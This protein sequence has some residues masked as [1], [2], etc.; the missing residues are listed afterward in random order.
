VD[1]IARHPDRLRLATVAAGSRWREVVALAMAHGAEAVALRD[2]EAAARAAERLAGTGVAVLSG[3]EGV[4]EA[5]AWPSVDVAVIA[6]SGIAGLVP[7]LAALGAGKDVA[8]ANKES[9]VAGGRLVTQAAAAHGARLLPVDSEH[10]A[11]FQCL[12]GRAA[13]GVRRLWLTASG[14]PFRTYP[15]RRLAQVTPAQA[16][17][18]PTW[19]MGPRVTV[20]SATLLNKGFE[21]IEASWLFGLAPQ[22]IQVVVHPQSVVHSFVEFVDGSVMAQCAVPD[23]RLPIQFALSY[24]ERWD[25]PDGPTL[26][27]RTVGRLDFE[28]PDARRFPC[29]DLARA[30]AEVGG[31]APAVLN[32]ADEVA[33][34]RFLSGELAFTD[35]PRLLADVLARHERAEDDR[36]DAIL[37]AD[38]WARRQAQGWRRRV[39][40]AVGAPRPPARRGRP[41]GRA[42]HGG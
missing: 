3:P 12:A 5:A 6:P 39:S 21:V 36:L 41:V 4:R 26:D 13:V 25:W 40:A 22:A 35:I 42:E 32:A 33:V 30:A 28:T 8:L 38:S 10:S 18:H 24:P 19:R 1:V 27:L 31:T 2:P 16:L 11:I 20:D 37:E 23:M 17:A 9:L 29:L 15:I 7:V 14:G 34:A